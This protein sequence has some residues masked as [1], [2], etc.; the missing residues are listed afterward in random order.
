MAT[1]KTKRS[2][3]T[4][5][6]RARAEHEAETRQRITEAA[7]E[8]HGSV[9]PARTTVKGVAERAGVQR[10][11]VYRHFPTDEDLFAACSAHWASLNPPPDFT[12]WG[13]DRDPAARLETALGQVYRWYEWAE[14][15]LACVLRDAPLVPAMDGPRQGMETVFDAMKQTLVK[16]RSERG[17]RRERVAAAIGHA[18]AFPTWH[19]LIREQGLE[20]DEAI[21]LMRELVATA[22]RL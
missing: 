8:M 1:Q 5:R 3:R 18:L 12:A 16:G 11:T 21:R 9:G 10:A 4:Y 19:S 7:M 6:K 22:G 14:P 13:E 17:R 15:M 20:R 2:P